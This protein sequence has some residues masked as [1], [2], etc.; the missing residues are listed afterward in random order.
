MNKLSPYRKYFLFLFIPIVS[1]LLHWKVFSYELGGI[2]AWRQSQT[3]QNIL[4]FYRYDA[5]ILNPRTNVID[6]NQQPTILRY[7]FPILQWS[8]AMIFHVTGESFPVTRALMFLLGLFTLAGM[9]YWL[10]QFFDDVFIA[11]AGAWALCLSPIFYYYTMN[12]MPDNLALCGAI[13]SMV[14]FFKFLKTDSLLHVA[15]SALFLSLAVAAKLP[16]I[17]FFGAQGSWW[18]WS[19]FHKGF[20]HIGREI[21]FFLIF[22]AILS[23]ALLWYW[24]VIPAWEN[25][26][27]SG[28]FQNGLP[29]DV[30]INVL[31]Y[32]SKEMFPIKLLGFSAVPF[33]LMGLFFLIK[34]K[35][36]RDLRFWWLAGMGIGVLLYWIFE[37][38]M[39]GVVHDYYM[40]PFL[41]VLYFIAAYGIMQ[42]MKL[43]RYVK[44]VTLSLLL[45]MPIVTYTITKEYWSVKYIAHVEDVYQYSDD[46][47]NAA[48]NDARCIILNDYTT[49][50]FSYLI[51]KRGFVFDHDHL[52][53]DW[54]KD[55]ITRY[56][57]T[58]LYSTSRIVDSDPDVT[59]YFDSLVME[60]G[61]VR[62]YKLKKL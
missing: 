46:L 38:N 12:P 47:R 44:W 51:D 50:L 39:I 4:N 6:K 57:T 28:I 58:Y 13:W 24:W 14:F 60:R 37:F 52:P 26:V 11:W 33:L 20:K 30:V 49:Y 19:I 40:M 22:L 15:G 27:T 41:P 9:Y 7:E 43:G 31:R 2:H 32:H 34:R 23:P 8:V 55:M 10:R 29:W 36:W 56:G 45:S 48:P 61:N 18:L 42:C 59:Q 21:R 17:V 1:L 62:V 3:Q 25:G 35:T 54:V 5:N 53:G 16:F